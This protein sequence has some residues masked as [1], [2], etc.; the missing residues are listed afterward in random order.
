M[1]EL[2]ILQEI[3]S[4]VNIIKILLTLIL[5]W[6]IGATLAGRRS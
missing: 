6:I 4:S 2:D 5:G 1:N 3:A